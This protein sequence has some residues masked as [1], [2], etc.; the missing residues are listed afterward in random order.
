VTLPPDLRAEELEWTAPLEMPEEDA[1]LEVQEVSFDP[2]LQQTRFHLR[3]AGNPKA[4]SFSVGFFRKLPGETG[5]LGREQ[6]GK[7]GVAGPGSSAELVSLRRLATLHL[8]SQNSFATLQVR[9]LEAGALGQVIRVRVPSNG[10]TLRARV[11]GPD[12]LDAVF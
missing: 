4:P 10:H 9:P 3:V 5:L 2:L 1:Q 8:H 11:A 12:A 6:A 7:N